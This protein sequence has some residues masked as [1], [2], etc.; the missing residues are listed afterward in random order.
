[1]FIG[2]EQEINMGEYSLFVYDTL[3]VGAECDNL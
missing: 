2:G 1:M 3:W